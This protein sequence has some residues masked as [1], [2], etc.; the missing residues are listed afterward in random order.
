MKNPIF[1]FSFYNPNPKPESSSLDS[2]LIIDKETLFL[3]D[4]TKN[5]INNYDNQK[6]KIKKKV[7]YIQQCHSV[8]FTIKSEKKELI[9]NTTLNNNQSNRI[10]DMSKYI[11]ELKKELNIK[12]DLVDKQEKEIT[13]LNNRLEKI[14][15]SMKNTEKEKHLKLKT[16]NID[17]KKK[18]ED[19]NMELNQN[20]EKLF[21]LKK[22]NEKLKKLFLDVINEVNHVYDY[23]FSHSESS[24]SDQ[25]LKVVRMFDDYFNEYVS[26][27]T[28]RKDFKEDIL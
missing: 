26:S 27:F 13:F 18:L 25:H 17:L 21:L 1:N 28:L 5:I 10:L 7:E 3:I 15:I 14:M 8:F 22:E 12:N 4:K 11:K 24:F 2:N 16:E 9:F 19:R 23:I 6:L 20:D